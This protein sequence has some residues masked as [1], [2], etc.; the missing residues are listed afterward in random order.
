M[1]WHNN[2]TIDFDLHTTLLLCF[3]YWLVVFVVC[4]QARVVVFAAGLWS[5]VF[6]P[7]NLFQICGNLQSRQKNKYLYVN[8]YEQ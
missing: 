7:L 8:L 5:V 4:V 2:T 3:T 1:F 6:D